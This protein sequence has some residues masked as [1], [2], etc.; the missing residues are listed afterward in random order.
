VVLPRYV[1]VNAGFRELGVFRWGENVNNMVSYF[2]RYRG[3]SP[4]LEAF[5]SHYET[6]HAAILRQFP[7]IRSLILHRPAAWI[8]PFPVRR[9]ESMLLAQMQFDSAAALDAAL[10]S[11]ARRQARDDFHQFPPFD[12]EVTHEAMTGKVI[13]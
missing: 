8:D 4:D 2:V 6:R 3:S 12:G 13:F 7:N 1:N 10:C 9:G 11:E 5:Q